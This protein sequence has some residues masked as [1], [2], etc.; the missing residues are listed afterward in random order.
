MSQKIQPVAHPSNKGLV[1]M[2][3]QPQASENFV[4]APDGVA[5]IPPG[6]R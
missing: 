2:L 3:L 6:W 4:H 1:G 5:Q